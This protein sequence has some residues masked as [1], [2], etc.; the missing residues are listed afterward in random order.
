M[1]CTVVCAPGSI[2]RVA[3]RS[4]ASEARACL[5][6]M[7]MR[8][9]LTEVK[10]A[11][12]PERLITCRLIRSEMMVLLQADEAIDALESLFACVPVNLIWCYI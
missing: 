3:R 1:I 2:G 10:R 4:A 11:Y 7:M 12:I 6:P 8:V 5:R 9:F